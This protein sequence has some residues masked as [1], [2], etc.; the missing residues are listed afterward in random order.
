MMSPGAEQERTVG[1]LDVNST[2]DYDNLCSLD[3]LGLADTLDHKEHF[4]DEFKEQLVMMGDLRPL[5]VSG[6]VAF[7][8]V[9]MYPQKPYEYAR[10]ACR[11]CV[12]TCDER[13][14]GVVGTRRKNVCACACT[15]K[16]AR[17]L[18]AK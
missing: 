11:A 4:M 16:I 9:H 7:S 18:N 3:I 2:T 10:I 14:D 6:F 1:C 5:Y 8:T 13:R 17:N 15:K 12:S